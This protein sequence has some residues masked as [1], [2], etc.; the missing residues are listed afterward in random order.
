MI[1]RQIRR[2]I[3]ANKGIWL[4]LHHTNRDGSMFALIKKELSLYFSNISGGLISGIFLLVTGLF[5][6]VIP[7]QWNVF[8]S[9]YAALDGFFSLAP[10]LYLFLIPAISMRL[11]ADEYRLGTIELLLTAPLSIT[12]IVGAKYIAGLIVILLSLIPTLLYYVSIYYMATPVGNVDSGAILG[13]YIG[14]FFLAAIYLSIGLWTSS[15]SDNQ[16]IAFLSALLMCYVFY[17][18]LDFVAVVF[19]GELAHYI[20]NGGIAAHYEAM[21]RGVLQLSDVIYYFSVTLLFL[22]FTKIHIQR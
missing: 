3:C 2:Y 11:F 1:P 4:F 6:W 12:K 17:A 21:S 5:L 15:F 13:S 10:W 9:N 22:F 19:K 20:A 16:M 18:G 7:G 8:S 14:L